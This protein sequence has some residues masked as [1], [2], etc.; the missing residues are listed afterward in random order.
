MQ[1]V[2]NAKL[3]GPPSEEN[4]FNATTAVY[5]DLATVVDMYSYF[6]GSTLKGGK[7]FLYLHC[8]QWLQT[9][10]LWKIIIAAT[11]ANKNGNK[12]T[13]EKESIESMSVS[14]EETKTAVADSNVSERRLV[15]SKRA[16][17]K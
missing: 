8:Y 12:S 7:P 11:E 1:S 5:N 4:V 2:W 3:T 17:G 14:T 6:G 9:T 13:E 16:A 15:G 10:Q